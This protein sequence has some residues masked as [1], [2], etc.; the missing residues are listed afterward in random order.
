MEQLAVLE[1][2]F[3]DVQKR[4]FSGELSGIEQDSSTS[5]VGSVAALCSA[6]FPNKA[7]LEGQILDWLSK[8]QGG[9]ILTAG[10]RRAILATFS[11]NKGVSH[12]IL[13]TIMRKS[14]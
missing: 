1:A 14:D 5:V 11:S 4:Y 12:S 7:Y 13:N 8:G 2:I 10:L 3:Y 6:V 9:A